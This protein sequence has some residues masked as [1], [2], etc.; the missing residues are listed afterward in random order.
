MEKIG[1]IQFGTPTV[2]ATQDTAAGRLTEY[3]S[4]SAAQEHSKTLS[5]K[6]RAFFFFLN[7]RKYEGHDKNQA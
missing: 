7:F 3:R 4:S 6:W 5:I 1:Q 2:P